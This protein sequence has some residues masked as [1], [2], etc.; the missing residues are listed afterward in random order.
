MLLHRETIILGGEMS[1]LRVVNSYK[2]NKAV[3]ELGGESQL[4]KVEEKI[5][6]GKSF[7][8]PAQKRK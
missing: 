2:V 7:V 6:L 3:G 1:A 8:V 5:G 4:S